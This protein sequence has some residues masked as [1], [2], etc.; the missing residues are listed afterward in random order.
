MNAIAAPAPAPLVANIDCAPTMLPLL[1]SVSL[2]EA[3]VPERVAVPERVPVAEAL[4]AELDTFSFH[5]EAAEAKS[6]DDAN[7][8]QLEE[9]GT[10]AV[11]GMVEIG[12]RD[13]G[14]WV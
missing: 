13:S 9:A 2:A 3:P 5:H 11:Y 14:G 1:E 10:R 12:P 4:A 6:S 8:V 7:W